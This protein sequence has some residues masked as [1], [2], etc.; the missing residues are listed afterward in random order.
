MADEENNTKKRNIFIRILCALGWLIVTIFLGHAVVGGIVG[1]LAG[2]SLEPPTS[3][4]EA[5]QAGAEAGRTAAQAFMVKHGGDLF[6]GEI[7]VW[8]GLV[9][10][11]VYPGTG[12]YKKVK[13]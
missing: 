4:S 8:V 1:G 9:I 12:K 13:V 7:I 10:F 6:L 11:G 3:I 5:Y 2:S